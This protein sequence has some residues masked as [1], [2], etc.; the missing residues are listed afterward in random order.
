MICKSKLN[1]WSSNSSDLLT[2]LADR[3]AQAA[4]RGLARNGR[5]YQLPTAETQAANVFWLT[6]ACSLE[7]RTE[8]MSECCRRTLDAWDRQRHYNQWALEALG[9]TSEV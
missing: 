9:D 1:S 3:D 6:S 4:L 5:S 8:E 2:P 7:M